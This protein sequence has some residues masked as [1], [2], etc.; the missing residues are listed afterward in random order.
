MEEVIDSVGE[1]HVVQFITDNGSQYKT[2]GEL[3]MEQRP[4]IYWTPCA[5]HCIDLILMDI[6]KIRRVQQVVEIAQT[7]IR[8]IYNHTWVL[9]L[10]RTYTG[11]DITRFAINYIALDSL[12]RKKAVLR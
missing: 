12:L 4:Q 7:I 3:L 11:R 8:F 1:Q 10:I 2:V 5:A 9:S 6:E